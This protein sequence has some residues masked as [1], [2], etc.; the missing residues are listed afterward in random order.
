L[1]FVSDDRAS[2]FDPGAAVLRHLY[3]SHGRP[4][5]YVHEGDR[6]FLYDGRFF[7]WLTDG[8]V[9]DGVYRGEVLGDR[10]LYRD[11]KAGDA[12][13]AAEVPF[14]PGIPHRP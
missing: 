7:G 3:D 8:G 11:G 9:W 10:L 13:P 14:A 5:A 4:I 12:R 1:L 2:T 6:V